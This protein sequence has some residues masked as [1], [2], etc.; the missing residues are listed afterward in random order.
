MKAALLLPQPPSRNLITSM[1]PW[2]WVFVRQFRRSV[3]SAKAETHL[4]FC[5]SV[6]NGFPPA[7]E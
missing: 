3:V 2:R 6:R 7:R 4:R 5:S 1:F